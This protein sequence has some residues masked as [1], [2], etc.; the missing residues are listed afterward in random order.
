GRRAMQSPA[1]PGRRGRLPDKADL[2]QSQIR[3]GYVGLPRSTPD[4]FPV[5][6][7][8]YI[9]GGGGLAS[10]LTADVRS[11]MGLTYDISSGYT[12]GV[13]PG[14]FVIETFTKNA[15]VKQSIDATL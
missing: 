7:M 10:R 15:T 14:S 6:V 9:L 8:N 5:Q 1:R 3:L 4:Y 12:Y 13:D 2:T 11:K